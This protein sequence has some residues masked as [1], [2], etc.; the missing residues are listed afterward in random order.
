MGALFNDKKLLMGCL[1]GDP[2][3]VGPTGAKLVSMELTGQDA[4]GG[5]VYLMTFDDGTTAEF[6]APRGEPGTPG[7]KGEPGEP[8]GAY[9]LT[10]MDKAEIANIVLSQLVEY[11]GTVE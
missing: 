7:D 4:D 2:G 5:N 8:G 3:P 9:A 1:K 10:T 11:D 6:V